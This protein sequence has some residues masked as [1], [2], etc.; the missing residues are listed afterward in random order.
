MSRG[1]T[2]KITND[3]IVRAAD[4]I[5]RDLLEGAEPDRDVCMA[6]AYKALSY[7]INPPA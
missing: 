3:M 6:I 2:M 5:Y 1:G 7:A 4:S